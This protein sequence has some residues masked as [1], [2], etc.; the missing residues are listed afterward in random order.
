[1]L[2]NYNYIY[3]SCKCL[4]S[5]EGKTNLKLKVKKQMLKKLKLQS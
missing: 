4:K 5:L 1:M 3:I 2:K